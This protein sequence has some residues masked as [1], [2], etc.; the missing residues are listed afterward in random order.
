M[1]FYI[2]GG[3][4]MANKYSDGEETMFLLNML[5]NSSF[6]VEED[7]QTLLD[8]ILEISEQTLFSEGVRTL[9]KTHGFE[10]DEYDDKAICDYI[11]NQAKR[12]K[13]ITTAKEQ[14]VFKTSISNW[15]KEGQYD[16]TKGR[17]KAAPDDNINSRLNVYKLCFSLGLNFEEVEEFF[18]KKYLCKP[19]NLRNLT[20]TV[21]FYALKNNKDYSY[22]VQL[23][24]KLEKMQCE[25]DSD[26]L[27]YTATFKAGIEDN[28]DEEI[29]IEYCHKNKDFFSRGNL[30]AIEQIELI[31]EDCYSILA[32]ELYDEKSTDKVSVVLREI[33][34]GEPTYYDKETKKWIKKSS[35]DIL[36]KLKE[37]VP[38]K[39]IAR[40]PS[41]QEISKIRNGNV[42]SSEVIRKALI[43]LNFYDFFMTSG[44]D[45]T[46]DYY[47]D[48]VRELNSLLDMCG[49]IQ[50][51]A[52]NSY[53]WLFLYCAKQTHPIETFKDILDIYYNN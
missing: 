15:L 49:F 9:C 1:L 53:D 39:I 7:P 33:Y 32:D 12:N 44:D 25:Y 35:T 37:T 2:D 50:C 52:R 13:V 17:N 45:N 4:T 21:F 34:G 23:I 11:V 47:E 19:F 6:N 27:L 46:E 24:D 38:R 36:K 48:Y 29:F 28:G 8:F 41:E 40:M 3:Y 30:T 20:E 10:G 18:L 31:L 16:S 22:A 14:N 43:L 42:V 5:E 26:P 51:Y